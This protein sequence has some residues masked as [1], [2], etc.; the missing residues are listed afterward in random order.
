MGIS[1]TLLGNL[2]ESQNSLGFD[3]AEF[4]QVHLRDFP[5]TNGNGIEFFQLGIQ[6]RAIDFTGNIR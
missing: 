6:E 1:S 5:T 3:G 4:A 2:R